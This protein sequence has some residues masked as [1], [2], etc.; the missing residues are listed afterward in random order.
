MQF[1]SIPFIIIFPIVVIL[2]YL[3]PKRLRYIW[4]LVCSYCFYFLAG[5]TFI[6]VLAASTVITYITGI[7]LD[8]FDNE[9]TRRAMV[10]VSAVL[11]LLS[12]FVFKFGSGL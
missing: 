2:Y 4:L 8:S 1:N 6:A 10:A 3:I 12:L 5:G 11:Q 9:K 7:A